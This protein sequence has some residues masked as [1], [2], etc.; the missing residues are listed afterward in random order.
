[1]SRLN[2][3]ISG[4]AFALSLAGPAA[5]DVAVSGNFNAK[6]YALIPFG[7]AGGVVDIAYA[8]GYFDPTF[9]LFDAAGA[10]LV[11]NDDSYVGSAFMFDA[12]LTQML[13]AGS[14][15]LLVSYCCQSVFYAGD[16]GALSAFTDGYNRGSYWVGGSGSLEGMRARLDGMAPTDVIVNAAYAVTIGNAV[17]RIPEPESL[18]LLA[19]GLAGLGFSWSRRA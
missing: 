1:M 2:K 12:H 9:S 8:G 13:S 5:A 11:T 16:N 4:A 15:S 7:T 14:Y 19:L 17:A 6:G 18:T 3:L 10:H